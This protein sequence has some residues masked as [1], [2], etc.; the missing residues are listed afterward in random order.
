[1]KTKKLLTQKLA[2]KIDKLISKTI[3]LKDSVLLCD[4]IKLK[5]KLNSLNVLKND[6]LKLKLTNDQDTILEIDKKYFK[7][8]RKSKSKKQKRMQKT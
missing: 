1:M 5:K 6:Y 3:D 2:Q 7:W 8:R 4:K